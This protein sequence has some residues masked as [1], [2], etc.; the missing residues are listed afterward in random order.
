MDLPSRSASCRVASRL[1][2]PLHQHVQSRTASSLLFGPYLKLYIA[3]MLLPRICQQHAPELQAV[4]TRIIAPVAPELSEGSR[5]SVC[6]TVPKRA[7]TLPTDD[8][9]SNRRVLFTDSRGAAG[10]APVGPRY[11]GS[12]LD[13]R[14]W[15]EGHGQSCFQ[16]WA[17]ALPGE[18]YRRTEAE[19]SLH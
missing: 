1:C 11:R 6:E 5:S 19:R 7:Q 10:L 15:P 17:T 8:L 4:R 16:N 13:I 14:R 2:F 18:D 9:T 12:R 3:D